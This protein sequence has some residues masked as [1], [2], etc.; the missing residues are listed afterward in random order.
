MKKIL[1]LAA[2]CAAF[3]TTAAFAMERP[4]PGYHVGI[5][6]KDV[7]KADAI[8][9]NATLPNMCYTKEV[10]NAASEDYRNAARLA[11]HTYAIG[12]ISNEL[13][14]GK[15]RRF[16]MN[17]S[18]TMQP[19]VIS[20]TNYTLGGLTQ[21][22]TVS[23]GNA[24]AKVISAT[25]MALEKEVNTSNLPGASTSGFL[26]WAVDSFLLDIAADVKTSPEYKD[27]EMRRAVLFTLVGMS[28][29]HP[30][31]LTRLPASAD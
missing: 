27:Y 23:E 11:R 8:C 10:L 6:S 14:N 22:S 28:L 12:L 25:F 9:V 24:P 4:G 2:V 5:N 17:A 16:E 15:N 3:A 26:D 13:F 21:F 18:V 29:D 1:T 31:L 20:T 7:N 19:R 30:R